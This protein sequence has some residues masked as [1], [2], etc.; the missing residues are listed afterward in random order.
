MKKKS[1]PIETN[2]E[3]NNPFPKKD[4]SPVIPQRS[5]FRGNLNIYDRP[6]TPKQLEFLEIAKDKDTKIMFVSGPAGTSKTYLSVLHAL[7]MINEKRVSDLIYIRSAVESADSKL[8]FLPG[9]ADE[10]MAPYLQPLMDKLIE[11][12]PKGD[13]DALQKDGRFTS[14]PVGFLRGL[15]WN[16]KVIVADEAQNLTYKELFTLITRTGEFSKVFILGD[17][18]QSDI[19]GKSGFIKMVNMFND[20]ESRQNGIHVFEFTDEDIVRSGLVKFIIQ[21][22]RTELTP[23]K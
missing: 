8:G 3:N 7:R 4:N 22:A 23:K 17:P 1:K 15:N 10:K 9:E 12:L 18:E 21:R 5:K 2:N 19:N 6:L 11:L 14:I 13:I 20:E 16:A